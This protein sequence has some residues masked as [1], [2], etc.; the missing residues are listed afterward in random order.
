MQFE[1]KVEAIETIHSLN[2]L[3]ENS[4]EGVQQPS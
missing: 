2:H 3:G 1:N 4:P